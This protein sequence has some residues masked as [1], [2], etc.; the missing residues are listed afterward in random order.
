MTTDELRAENDRLRSEVTALKAALREA[1]DLFYTEPERRAAGFDP[2]HRIAEL[3]KLAYV[4]AL[5]RVGPPRPRRARQRIVVR[6]A[7]SL[8]STFRADELGP[9]YR[10]R[11]TDGA[12]PTLRYRRSHVLHDGWQGWH[13]VRSRNGL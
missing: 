13:D 12:R 9:V 6:S 4:G 8:A 2:A 7:P 3:R 10:D 11:H 1:C 5:P